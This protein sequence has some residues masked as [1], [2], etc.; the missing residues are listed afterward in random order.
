MLVHVLL[1]DG[2]YDLYK[3]GIL[4]CLEIKRLEHYDWLIR[5]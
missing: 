2:G 1:Y 5:V 3:Y 4:S